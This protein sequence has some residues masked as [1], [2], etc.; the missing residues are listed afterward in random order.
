[1]KETAKLSTENISSLVATG[2]GFDLL[3]YFTLPDFLGK[4]A[5]YLLYFMGKN[6]ARE[7][8]IE[9]YEELFEFFQY[10]GWGELQLIKEKRRELVFH[11]QGHI[12]EKRLNQKIYPI[13]FR[14]ECGFLAEA[15][16]TITEDTYECIEEVHPKD[17]I[18]EIKATKE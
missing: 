10:L 13:D 5:P 16:Q 7:T 17:H 6:I 4:D 1:M 15:L 8:T 2:A 12:V 9:T 3:R 14:L 18:I 11:L